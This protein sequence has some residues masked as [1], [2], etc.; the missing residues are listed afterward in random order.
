MALVLQAA[1]LLQ[2]ADPALA[3][4]FCGARL[5][6]KGGANYGTLPGDLPLAAIIEAG[7]PELP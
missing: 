3:T 5:D 4:A 6:G 2:H 1:L 7:R